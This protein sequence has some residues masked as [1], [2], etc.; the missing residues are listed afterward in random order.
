MRGRLAIVESGAGE[1]CGMLRTRRNE[2]D[3]LANPRP[4]SEVAEGA[5]QDLGGARA[6]FD[7]I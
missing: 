3:K 2:L 4:L 1:D 5:G 6:R 7:S